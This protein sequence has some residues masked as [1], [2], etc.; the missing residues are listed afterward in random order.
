M[1]VKAQG[2]I[3]FTNITDGADGTDGQMLYGACNTASATAAKVPAST[4]AGFSLAVGASVAIKFTYA[5]SSDA[6]TLNVNST[7][8]KA[9]RLNGADSVYWAAGATVQMVYD[10]TYWQVC[11]TPLYGSEATIGNPSGGNVYVDADSVDIRNGATVLST[12]AA[13]LIELGK[14]ST[15]AVIK[16]CG[17]VGSIRQTNQITIAGDNGAVLQSTDG[18]T[19]G[20]DFGVGISRSSAG[21]ETAMVSGDDVVING[22]VDGY[23][24][25]E[26]T[27]ANEITWKVLPFGGLKVACGTGTWKSFTL[28]GNF[29]QTWFQ[30]VVIPVPGGVFLHAPLSG[31]GSSGG[32]YTLSVSAY[33]SWTATSVRF[34]VSKNYQG[35]PGAETFAIVLWGV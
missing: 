17:G 6:P 4:I 18:V 10:G 31:I 35:D 25:A 5:N 15:S 2:D 8:A 14:N 29:N 24:S 19:A 11:N 32:L 9:I 16:M 27:Y 3:T 20:S 26:S 34:D 7:G 1:T 28:S 21:V 22:F 23:T 13:A 33:A 12:I 30:Q